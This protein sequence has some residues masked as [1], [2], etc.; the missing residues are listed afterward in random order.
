[1]PSSTKMNDGLMVWVDCYCWFYKDLS[2]PK[3]AKF[4]RLLN[5][6][7]QDTNFIGVGITI[8]DE[9]RIAVGGWAVFLVLNMP[10]D[11]TW[12]QRIEQISIFPGDCLKH[13]G[14]SLGQM[15]SGSHYCQI[16]LAWD[17]VRN[18]STKAFVSSNTVL[19]EFAHS[20][21]YID[22]V[23]D[24][25]PSVLLKAGEREVWEKAFSTGYIF[26]KRTHKRNQ[27]WH[28]FG[29]GRW[30][31][32]D[33]DNPGCVDVGELFAVST[34][35]FFESPRSLLRQAPEIYQCLVMLYKCNPIDDF[36]K[37]NWIQRKLNMLIELLKR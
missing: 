37:R 1:M 23:I 6:F 18:S 21:D 14:Q 16:E 11:I 3:Q 4:I 2:A 25:S 30:N 19:H 8:T 28:F 27:L 31:E 29:L 12:Y 36:P 13:Q 7:I 26:E 22:R 10:L 24:G 35:L 9:M 20:L 34:E 17:E 33:P 15:N 32:F 5:A